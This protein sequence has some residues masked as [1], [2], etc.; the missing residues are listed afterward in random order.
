MHRNKETL[1][2][3][4]LFVVSAWYVRRLMK[5][6]MSGYNKNDPKGTVLGINLQTRLSV[7]AQ[8]L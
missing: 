7:L 1:H 3:Q 6:G 8:W 2:S 4:A 5:C